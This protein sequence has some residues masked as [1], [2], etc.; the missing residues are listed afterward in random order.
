MH[1]D[2]TVTRRGAV[3]GREPNQGKGQ[4]DGQSGIVTHQSSRESLQC[5]GPLAPGLWDWW[6]VPTMSAQAGHPKS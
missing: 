3:A 1:R 2:Q 5:W 4:P 6:V